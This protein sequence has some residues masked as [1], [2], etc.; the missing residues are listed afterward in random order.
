MH[1]KLEY[2]AP[3]LPYNA[4]FMRKE[5]ICLDNTVV[6]V[7]WSTEKEDVWTH[8][9]C[10]S[11]NMPNYAFQECRMI[12]RPMGDL[13]KEIDINGKNVLP[14]HEL[15]LIACPDLDRNDPWVLAEPN[16]IGYAIRISP[17]NPDYD[18]SESMHCV[19]GYDHISKCFGVHYRPSKKIDFTWN[20]AQL[21]QKLAE[22]HFDYMGLIDE[23]L[24]I[25]MNTLK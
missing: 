9:N 7:I 13:V 11:L 24:A 6:P 25:D 4:Y 20:Q 10:V 19:F 15:A 18:F 16:D 21:F 3:Y 5:L 22:M 12:L 2:Y 14:I 1:Q 23:G 17:E 8:L